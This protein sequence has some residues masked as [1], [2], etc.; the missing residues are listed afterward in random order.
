VTLTTHPPTSTEVKNQYG[1]TSTPTII[2]PAVTYGAETWTLTSKIKKN[3]ND[4]GEIDIEEN[5]WTN[6][7]KWIVEN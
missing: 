7:G 3:V 6:K 1:Y 4:T 2:R 5:I